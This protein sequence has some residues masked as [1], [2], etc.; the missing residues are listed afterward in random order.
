M[1]YSKTTWVDDS[2]PAINAT[3]LNKIEVG[4]ETAQTAVGTEVDAAAFTGCLTTDDDTTQKAFETINTLSWTDLLFPMTQ[5]AIN[6]TTSKP[7]FDST[8]LGML[9]PQNDPSE[10]VFMIGQMPHEYI[11]GS[12]I[13][14]HIHLQ[15]SVSDHPTFEL[16]YKWFNNSDLVPASWTTLE[17]TTG[18]FTY[19]SGNLAQIMS[20]SEIDGSSISGAS[21]MLLFKLRRTDNIVTGDVLVWE[22][23]IHY[24]MNMNGTR[25]EFA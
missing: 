23:D 5:V 15:Q 13:R 25:T 10:E 20:F 18:V 21:S 11:L 2:V 6:R 16:D 19:T 14:P 8:N 24:Q 22:F 1:S 3:N 12:N 4:V 17:A 9:F 7:D